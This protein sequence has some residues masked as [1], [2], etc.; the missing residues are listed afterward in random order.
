MEWT[1]KNEALSFFAEKV[2]FGSI[3]MRGFRIG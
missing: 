1:E 3:S 2:T